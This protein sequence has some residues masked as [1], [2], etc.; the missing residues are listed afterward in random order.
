M[1]YFIRLVICGLVVFFSPLFLKDI[2]TESF[3]ASIMVAF[4][5]SILNTFVRPIAKILTFPINFL[6]LG[7]FSFVIT[8]GFVY[9]CAHY[10][11]GFRVSGF[12]SPLLLGLIVSCANSIIYS[13]QNED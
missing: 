10:I 1:N 2:K 7:L 8:V 11:K 5:M 13:F 9:V 12:L 3:Q 6:T 4:G